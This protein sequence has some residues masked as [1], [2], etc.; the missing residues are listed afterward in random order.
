MGELPLRWDRIYCSGGLLV[1]A[2]AQLLE[3]HGDDPDVPGKYLLRADGGKGIFGPLRPAWMVGMMELP[4]PPGTYDLW[5]STT[6]QAG[7]RGVVTSLPSVT[8]PPLQPTGLT[9]SDLVLGREGHDLLWQSATMAV[10]LNP[11]GEWLQ[12]ETLTLFAHVSGLE[13]GK[14][15]QVKIEFTALDPDRAKDPRGRIT[16]QFPERATAAE[17]DWYKTLAVKD[18]EPGRYTT[19]V[20]FTQGEHSITRAEEMRVFKKYDWLWP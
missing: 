20:T 17:V 7:R 2:T 13:A 1:E 18:L 6:Q 16:I 9:A 11:L 14:D 15:F 8:I 5:F 12:A 3:C 10:P 4:L 19:R